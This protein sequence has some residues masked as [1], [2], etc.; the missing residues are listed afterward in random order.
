MGRADAL[1][2][3]EGFFVTHFSTVKD[4][5]TSKEFYAG[6]LGGRVVRAE[7]PCYIKLA[8]SR[9][10]LISGGGTRPTH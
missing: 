7:D 2:T 3:H 9:V 4:Q 1:V 10:I 8:N 6:I 5:A